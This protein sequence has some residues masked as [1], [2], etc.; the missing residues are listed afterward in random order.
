MKWNLR[1]ATFSLPSG[2]AVRWPGDAFVLQISIFACPNSFAN[3]FTYIER[4]KAY[5]SAR[6]S[7]SPG[8]DASIAQ[9]GAKK[10]KKPCIAITSPLRS[11]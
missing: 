7:K 8:F 2:A 1:P 9:K 6:L 11:W 3:P 4:P 10:K 5:A